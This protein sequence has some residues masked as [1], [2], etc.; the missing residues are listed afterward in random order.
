MSNY[1][2]I[3][4]IIFSIIIIISILILYFITHF[5]IK[6]YMIDKI[7]DD[8]IIVKGDI[9]PMPID[10]SSDDYEYVQT[11]YSLCTEGTIIRDTKGKNIK[12]IDL[13]EGDNIK[14]IR[15]ISKLSPQSSQIRTSEY[16]TRIIDNIVY[17]KVM[18]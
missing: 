8:E 12:T 14:I 17:I 7:Y 18:K 4:I 16:I 3:I 5:S 9:I 10:I 13:N 1:K 11:F 6:F 15:N 2:K